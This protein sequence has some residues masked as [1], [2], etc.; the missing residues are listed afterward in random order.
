MLLVLYAGVDVRV[1]LADEVVV[2][3]CPMFVDLPT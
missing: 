1:S 3:A 2:N